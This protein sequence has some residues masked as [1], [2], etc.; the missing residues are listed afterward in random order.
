MNMTSIWRDIEQEE[1]EENIESTLNLISLAILKKDLSILDSVF[2]E[3]AKYT[4]KGKTVEGVPAIK[5]VVVEDIRNGSSTM[6][7]F[8]SPAIVLNG[9]SATLEAH[10]Q[11]SRIG[12]GERNIASFWGLV[13]A[14]FQKV[15]VNQEKVWRIESMTIDAAPLGDPVGVPAPPAQSSPPQPP[16]SKPTSWDTIP[17]Q[18]DGP[19][20]PAVV[21][22]SW[23]PSENK[24]PGEAGPV[25][26]AQGD[27]GFADPPPTQQ[28]RGGAAPAA[29]QT[30]GFEVPPPAPGP[31]SGRPGN[32]APP[33]PVQGAP[34]GRP[35]NPAQAA[36]SGSTGPTGAQ[37][38]EGSAFA[39]S[40]PA[41]PADSTTF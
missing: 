39:D 28:G 19:A 31:R 22:A 18:R 35:S 21:P 33:A 7:D 26:A 9:D 5:N 32:D 16:R 17:F 6:Y 38:P 13:T 23:M 2:L 20:R 37:F 40:A 24:Q 25:G 8:R 1:N 3:N 29:P 41:P 30:S 15:E 34:S 12:K 36:P 27:Q 10:L 14:T 4:V 11:A